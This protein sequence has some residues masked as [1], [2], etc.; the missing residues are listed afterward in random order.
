MH[1]APRGYGRNE[2]FDSCAGA[3]VVAAGNQQ[4]FSYSAEYIAPASQRQPV[5]GEEILTF[6]RGLADDDFV[7]VNLV[8]FPVGLDLDTDAHCPESGCQ[9]AD[10]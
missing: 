5:D 7:F 1:T 2:I 6:A 10:C 3:V 8:T 4:L 9:S